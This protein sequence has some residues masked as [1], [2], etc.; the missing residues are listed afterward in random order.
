ML[1]N[2]LKLPFWGKTML[3]LETQIRCYF[4]YLTF[5][6]ILNLL[7]NKKIL[8]TAQKKKKNQNKTTL[9]HEEDEKVVLI[10][11]GR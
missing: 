3:V 9:L 1:K 2:L 4:L 11:V 5:V 7:S 8:Y 10:K 6:L